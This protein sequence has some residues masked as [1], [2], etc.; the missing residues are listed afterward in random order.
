MKEKTF[1]FVSQVL[2][3]RLTNQTIKNVAAQ[4]LSKCCVPM[5]AETSKIYNLIK[6]DYEYKSGSFSMAIN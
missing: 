6:K 2:S 1:F 5:L 3:F 4:P